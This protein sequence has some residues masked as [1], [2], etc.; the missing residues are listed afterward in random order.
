MYI[1][2]PAG[3][4]D[5][6]EEK[7]GE[8]TSPLKIRGLTPATAYVMEV[9][10]VNKVG[11]GE[12]SPRLSFTTLDPDAPAP[13]PGPPAPPVLCVAQARSLQVAFGPGAE[14]AR[15]A[16]IRK[17]QGKNR[18]T[19]GAGGAGGAAA[20]RG[21]TDDDITYTVEW[22]P[23]YTV[24]GDWQVVAS[25]LRGP[26]VTKA[27]L[28]PG[29]EYYFRVTAKRTS[30]GEA[31]AVSEISEA[32]RTLTL[33]QQRE[34][35]AAN[36][37]RVKQSQ[38]Y[39]QKRA[40]ADRLNKLKRENEELRKRVVGAEES[41][42]AAEA[43]RSRAD[44][45]RAAA[46][47]ERD[48]IAAERDDQ[49]AEAR[50]RAQAALDASEAKDAASTA[51]AAALMA[52]V[53]AAEKAR[54]EANAEAKRRAEEAEAARKEAAEFQQVKEAE[55]AALAAQ[56][57]EASG[58]AAS[59]AAEREAKA[60]QVAELE[61]QLASVERERERGQR[62][63]AEAAEAAQVAESAAAAD[64]RRAMDEMAKE[65]S[66]LTIARED[67]HGLL[68][69]ALAESE[70]QKAEIR[71]L[72]AEV[73][74]RTAEA[75]DAEELSKLAAEHS[76]LI[77]TLEAELRSQAMRAESLDGPGPDP[78]LEAEMVAAGHRRENVR[79]YLEFHNL[80]GSRDRLTRILDMHKEIR[81]AGYDDEN[82]RMAI[83]LYP[84]DDDGRRKHL[85]ETGDSS[86]AQLD[87]ESA[88][89]AGGGGGGVGGVV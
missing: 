24:Y 71:R 1:T 14:D 78:A 65:L 30:T 29:S 87:C 20:P 23:T 16:A 33:E 68:D 21:S 84:D 45:A 41:K 70:A 80:A 74:A 4:A 9:R 26:Y 57:A 58:A 17:A 59:T 69:A 27:D 7:I 81:R 60:K 5:A 3:D 50:R 63:A 49:L 76:K 10:G 35:D 88:G 42:A 6:S 82:T 53:E 85:E 54:D 38:E 11:V 12:W 15:A 31:S 67:A 75:A 83:A 28:E 39:A 2:G 55:A 13:P 72:Q 36:E 61:A 37:A 89:G 25:G 47:S 34:V 77:D 51:A 56:L 79:F 44:A 66:L 52:K 19:A 46:E 62:D 64:A 86:A 73:A 43:A 8:V 48:R 32:F 18:F 40:E 22:T